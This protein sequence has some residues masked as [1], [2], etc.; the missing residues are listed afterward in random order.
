[1][2]LSPAEQIRL[3]L[4]RQGLTIADLAEK[5]GQSRQNLTNKLNRD[6]FQVSELETLASALGCELKIEFV[7]IG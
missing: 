4:R 7:Q 6:N 3:I 5:T 2:L 1:M